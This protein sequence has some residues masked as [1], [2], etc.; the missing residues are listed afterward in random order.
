MARATDQPE[1]VKSESA[2]DQGAEET[3]YQGHNQMPEG[4]C[5]FPFHHYSV[6][7]LT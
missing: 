4:H 2:S 3:K 1:L 5:L 6:T 7:S